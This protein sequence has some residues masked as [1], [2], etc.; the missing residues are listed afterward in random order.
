MC[1]HSYNGSILQVN[2]DVSLNTPVIGNCF[3]SYKSRTS[4]CALSKQ[5]YLE[6]PILVPS[7]TRFKMSLRT[8]RKGG[9]GPRMRTPSPKQPGIDAKPILPL[10]RSEPYLQSVLHIELTFLMLFD[11]HVNTSLLIELFS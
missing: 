4:N 6:C 1:L 5:C 10:C 9:S 11:F 3:Q 2:R 8:K 7:V